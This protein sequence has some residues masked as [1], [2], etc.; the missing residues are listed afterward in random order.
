MAAVDVYR[1]LWRH[2]VLIILLTAV[3]VGATAYFTSREAKT[4][5][6]STLARVQQRAAS[7]GPSFD[8]LEASARLAQTYAKV[9]DSGA[10]DKP[11]KATVATKLPRKR[12]FAVKLSASPVQDLDLIWISAR[13]HDPAVAAAAATLAAGQLQR[14]A[15]ATST[16]GTQI[17]TIKKATP[18]GSPTSPQIELN[19]G[20]ALVLGLI[21]NGALAL[22]IEVLRDRMP[23]PEDLGVSLGYP[24][25]ATIPTLELR[26]I[27]GPGGTGRS[28]EEAGIGRGRRRG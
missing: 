24:V 20:L 26:R 10:F 3:F 16:P 6:A 15:K 13:S 2:R 28:A 11:V 8:S 18:P 1:A 7:G 19:L 5:E 4:Y 17:V 21:F 23:D 12:N 27:T 9:I 25:L 14:F 22:L